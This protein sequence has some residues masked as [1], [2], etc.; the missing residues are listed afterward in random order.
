MPANAS[1]RKLSS[2]NF[3]RSFFGVCINGTKIYIAGGYDSKGNPTS[4][5]FEY[6]L[7]TKKWME[8]K[9]MSNAH[10]HFALE[11]VGGK[12]Y[13]IGGV[14]TNGSI[15]AYKPETDKW[16]PITVKNNPV[17]LKPL[18]EITASTVIENKI[19]LLWPST[20]QIFTPIDGILTEGT[21]PP[22]NSNYFDI[23]V[24]NKKLYVAGGTTDK[25]MDDGVYLYNA[26]DGSWSNVGKVPNTKFGSGLTYFNSMLLFL[27]GSKTD[28]SK[29]AEPV[30][31]INVYRPSK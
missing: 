29:P 26:V 17:N 31:E 28:I 6:D 4:S 7:I 10:A 1:L 14:N 11:C 23:A 18:L 13:A 21:K 25:G 8:K 19:C 12:L 30:D 22:V 3:V 20:F 15:E 27:G 24:S 16:E 9:A 5:L 2:A